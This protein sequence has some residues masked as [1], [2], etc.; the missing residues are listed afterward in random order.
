M[1]L[2]RSIRGIP[3]GRVTR[4]ATLCVYLVYYLC[5]TVG[6]Y[7]T[8]L[9]I[10]SIYAPSPRQVRIHRGRPTHGAALHAVTYARDPST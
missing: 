4:L 5:P 7:L 10:S 6:C 8:S 3:S 9:G 1:T 2:I